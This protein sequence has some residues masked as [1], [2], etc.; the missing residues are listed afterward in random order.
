MRVD[1]VDPLDRRARYFGRRGISRTV[2]PA[3]LD[4]FHGAELGGRIG[5][6]LTHPPRRNYI[7]SMFQNTCDSGTGKMPRT[8]SRNATGDCHCP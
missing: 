6:V 3:K 8:L 7:F 2:A 5:S 1:P 4:G